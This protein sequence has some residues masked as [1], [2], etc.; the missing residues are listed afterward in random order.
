[1]KEMN[2]SSGIFNDIVKP[3]LRTLQS[4]QVR[5]ETDW[6]ALSLRMVELLTP[7]LTCKV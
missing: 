7:P 3:A 2:S 1:M 5:V 6:P 4:V